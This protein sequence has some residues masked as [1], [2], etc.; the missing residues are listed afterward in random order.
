MKMQNAQTFKK[1][2]KKEN[3]L[4]RKK[5]EECRVKNVI[6]LITGKEYKMDK[7]NAILCFKGFQMAKPT[8]ERTTGQSMHKHS[9]V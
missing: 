2:K 9:N 5:N 6:I 3:Q 8:K 7:K 1:K 4:N